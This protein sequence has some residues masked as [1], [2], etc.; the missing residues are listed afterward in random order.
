MEKN[1]QTVSD[2]DPRFSSAEASVNGPAAKELTAQ[3]A[4]SASLGEPKF[5]VRADAASHA[6]F[7]R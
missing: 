6:Q 5:F 4:S 1:V 3:E 2:I 7:D